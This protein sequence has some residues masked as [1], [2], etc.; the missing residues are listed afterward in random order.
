MKE[1]AKRFWIGV[2]VLSSLVMLGGLIILFGTAPTMFKRSTAYTVLF[3][4]APNV[5]PGTPVRKAGVRIGEVR[6]VVLDD[7]KGEVRVTVAIEPQFT[8]RYSDQ[9][10]L[11]S[12]LLGSDATIDFVPLAPPDPGQPPL[13][14]SPIPPGSEIVGVRGATV[15]SL[16]N[17]AAD[18][19][20]PT[21]EAVDELRKTLQR[22]EKLT[23][24]AD[25]TMKEIR[26]LAR[27]VRKSV[28][29][30]NQTSDEVRALAKEIRKAV[31]D[32]QETLREL[33]KAMPEATEALKEVRQ[34]AK[35]TR[36]ALPEARSTIGDVGAAARVYTKLGERLNVLLETNQDKIVKVIDNL[37]ETLTRAADLLNEENRANVRGI[38]GDVRDGA[39]DFPEM[40][41]NFLYISREGRTSVKLLND[42]LKRVDDTLK[43]IQ[44]SNKTLGQRVNS[45]AVNLDEAAD[46]ANRTFTDVREL[47]RAVGQADGT[48]NRILT[49]PSLY[50]HID[51]VV[52][53]VGKVMPRLD[54][55]LKDVE[56]FADKLARHPESI[57][58]GGVVRPSSGLKEA[59]SSSFYPQ[60]PPR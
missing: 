6:D 32:A 56:T 52:M 4:E 10:R 25:E 47:V 21:R 20:P 53:M 45:I 41:R 31:P 33:R 37:N 16:L 1:Q 49:D 54:R 43:D 26:D 13:D 22:L 46:K 38:L 48:L 17:Q 35:S 34:L 7:D 40:S 57:G 3:T 27:D 18:V 36:E 51:E 2:F 19:V 23:P 9:A 50:N 24:V 30:L 39:R 44:G 29:G 11:T 55:I 15:N 8:L 5:G 14:R 42:S 60:V 12:G 28:P 59:P 58:I